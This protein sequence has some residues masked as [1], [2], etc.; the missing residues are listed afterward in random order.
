MY[1]YGPWTSDL[2]GRHAHLSAQMLLKHRADVN[3]RARPSGAAED[4]CAQVEVSFWM[5]SDDEVYL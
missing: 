1:N 5:F 2:Y 4:H 3:C